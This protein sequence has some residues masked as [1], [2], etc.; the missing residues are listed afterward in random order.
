MDGHSQCD[1]GRD[2]L[3]TQRPI[4]DRERDLVEGDG[5]LTC[6]VD[7]LAEH[8]ACDGLDDGGWC[9]VE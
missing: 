6:G 1:R 9:G 3:A 8:V 4:G 7:G 2:E 5:R